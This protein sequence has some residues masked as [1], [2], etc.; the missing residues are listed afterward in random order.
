MSFYVWDTPEVAKHF[1]KY[2]YD[3]MGVYTTVDSINFIYHYT[4][5]LDGFARQLQDISVEY[6]LHPVHGFI[7]ANSKLFNEDSTKEQE[8]NK[9]QQQET[10]KVFEVGDK[11]VIKNIDNK[12]YVYEEA[13]ENFVDKE[14]TIVSKFTIQSNIEDSDID[15]VSVMNENGQCICF[16]EEMCYPVKTEKEKA[17][18]GMLAVI[19]EVYHEDKINKDIVNLLYKAGYR[20]VGE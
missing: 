19:T 14:V 2:T 3:K 11:C 13:T 17:I 12:F 5:H 4:P 20:K 10:K 9:M 15:M 1:G 16:R 8:E 6:K 7:P 18:E